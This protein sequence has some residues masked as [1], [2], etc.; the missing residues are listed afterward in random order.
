MQLHRQEDG[1]RGKGGFKAGSHESALALRRRFHTDA[2]NLSRKVTQRAYKSRSFTRHLGGKHQNEKDAAEE[3]DEPRYS[4]AFSKPF[5]ISLR[6]GHAALAE[7]SSSSQSDSALSIL[8][9]KQSNY[10][11]KSK[12]RSTCRGDPREEQLCLRK[13][14][15]RIAERPMTQAGERVDVFVVDFLDVA[16]GRF[17][18]LLRPR[19]P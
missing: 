6:R 7:G 16:H 5:A 11:Q 4:C 18:Q 14:F 17:N 9:R 13:L 3:S 8:C 12:R 10:D 19:R 15:Q 2:P 1:M